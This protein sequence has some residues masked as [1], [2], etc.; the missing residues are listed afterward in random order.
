M[1]SLFC[2]VSR[3]ERN[4]CFFVATGEKCVFFSRDARKARRRGS[5]GVEMRVSGGRKERL[6]GSKRASLGVEE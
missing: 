5:S 1:F 3:D 4:E 2:F 6:W